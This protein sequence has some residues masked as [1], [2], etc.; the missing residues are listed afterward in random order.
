MPPL[1]QK[2]LVR[3]CSAALLSLSLVTPVLTQ[4]PQ[5]AAAGKATQPATVRLALVNVPDDLLR[6]LLPEFE[7]QTGRHAEIVYTGND[8]FGVAR[9]GKAAYA[10]HPSWNGYD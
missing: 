8:P 9:D 6:P 1:R 7:Q 10:G 3:A 5:T 4:G 2:G